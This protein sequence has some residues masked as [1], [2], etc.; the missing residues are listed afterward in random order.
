MKVHDVR[1][2]IYLY[3]DFDKEFFQ[4]AY[5][6]EGSNP[7]SSTIFRQKR[8]LGNYS[9]N[10]SSWKPAIYRGWQELTV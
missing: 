8:Q 7:S 6:D 3:P 10:W 4:Y 2:F 1:H 5:L 9:N